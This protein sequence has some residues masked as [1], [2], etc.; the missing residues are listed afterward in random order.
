MNLLFLSG[1][2]PFPPSNGSK[3][4]IYNLLRW[5]ARRHQVTL[6]T[7][8]EQPIPAIPPEL[9]AVCSAVH[10]LPWKEYSPASAKARFGYFRLTPR[11]FLDTYQSAMEHLIR[12]ILAERRF[13]LVIASQ[14]RTAVYWRAFRQIPAIFEE[15]E[16]GVFDQLR[17]ENPS[18]KNRLRYALTW[19]K[20]V[21]YMRR[22]LPNFQAA[23]LV[24]HA[25]AALF[26]RAVPD[27][28][29]VVLIPNCVDPGQDAPCERSPDPYGLVFTG[30]LTYAPNYQAMEW[31]VREVLPV[32]QAEIPQTS[33]IITGDPGQRGL[34][35]SRNV[36]LAGMVAD[37]RPVFAG[38]AVSV[39]PLFSGG[40]TRLKI[41]EAMV[42][43]VPVVSTRKGAEGLEVEHG[44]SIQLADTAQDFARAVIDLLTS[45]SRRENM[46]AI[47]RRLVVD[48]YNCEQVMTG[49][50]RLMLDCVPNT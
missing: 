9:D 6:I 46:A 20:L 22:I 8:S 49:F 18:G 40:G 5:L 1:W 50:E 31:F 42:N 41:L 28:E 30:S 17:R 38:A 4:R 35:E 37:L 7:F 39:A 21:A 15:V 45:P 12:K 43:C 44:R 34:P 11:A 14:W 2:F 29:K 19:V 33:L 26:R 32:I 23:T 24:S 13:D 25:E 36:R 16:L 48:R 27:Y 10:A 3:L 47:A